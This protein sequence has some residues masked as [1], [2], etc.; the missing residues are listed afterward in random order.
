MRPAFIHYGDYPGPFCSVSTTIKTNPTTGKAMVD[1]RTID[2]SS[3]GWRI[4]RTDTSAGFPRHSCLVA[5]KTARVD[6]A[7]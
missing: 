5:G 7:N 3:W 6:Y 2:G 4:V 1:C